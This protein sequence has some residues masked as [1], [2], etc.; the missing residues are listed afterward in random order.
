VET[1][2]RAVGQAI[3]ANVLFGGSVR[4]PQA[5]WV[6]RNIIGEALTEL[7]RESGGRGGDVVLVIVPEGRGPEV[8]DAVV[9]GAMVLTPHEVTALRDVLRLAPDSPQL[10]ER[11][12]GPAARVV[13]RIRRLA[14]C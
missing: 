1:A 11:F 4:G 8:L 6:R 12:G 3:T 2:I 5:R 7:E 14:G 9:N 13:G 10:A